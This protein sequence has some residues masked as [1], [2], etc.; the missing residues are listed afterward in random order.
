MSKID[1]KMIIFL[2]QNINNILIEQEMIF[3]ETTKKSVG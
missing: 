2:D 1:N 3:L